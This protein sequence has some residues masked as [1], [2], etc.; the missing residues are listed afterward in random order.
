MP[1]ALSPSTMNNSERS[2]SLLRQSASL[3]GSEEDSR[4][5]FLRWVSL[6]WR[7]L[8]RDFISATIFSSTR[9]AAALSSRLREV[10]Y[11]VSSRS[12]TRETMARTAGVPRTS[13]VCPS[14]CG[15]ASRTVT[16]AVSPARMS[17]FSTLSPPTLRR[18]ALL[19]SCLRTTLSIAWSKPA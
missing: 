17:S 3:A 10:R 14:N 16:T 7:A 18:R 13:L 9:E 8:I 5:F 6:C 11:A 19:S 15:S 2:T 4:A 12:T 1:R